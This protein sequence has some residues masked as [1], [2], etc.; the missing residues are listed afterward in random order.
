MSRPPGWWGPALDDDQRDL[1]VML[2]AFIAGHDPVLDD[3]PGAV[4]EL[5]AE[6]AGLG[7]W[8]VGTAESAGGGGAGRVLT[9]TVLERLGR[10]WPAL[11]W[12]SVQAHAAVDIVAGEDRFARLVEGVHAG[13]AAVA[14]VDAGSAHV[15]LD[16]N[17]DTVTG[18]VDRVDAAAEQPHLLILAGDDTAVLVESTAL[19][20]IPLRRSGFGG[21]FT[22]AVEIVGG[23]VHELTGVDV[24]AAQVRLRLGAA[25]VAAGIAG[26]AADD[27]AEYAANRH[28]FGGALT[29]IPTV[30][31]SLLGQSASAAVM[32][33]AVLSAA[34]DPVHAYAVMREACDG[35]IMVAAASLQAH[36]GYGYLTEY[37]AERRLR[38]AVSLRAAADVQGAASAAARTLWKDAS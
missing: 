33:A 25:A 6:L 24:T 4:A 30:R 9:S 36:G 13:E 32:L 29:A 11:G 21:A 20:A 5:V 15:H 38:D 34:A 7:V 26:A 28:Q 31:Q 23:D 16:R 14:V 18:S 17:G 8:T 35:A 19:S 1:R 10:A 2:D 3:E 37:P 22:R 27:A 12:A